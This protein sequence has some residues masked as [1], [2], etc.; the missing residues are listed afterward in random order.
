MPVCPQCNNQIFEGQKFCGYC[1]YKLATVPSLPCPRCGRLN[2]NSKFC[3]YCGVPLTLPFHAPSPPKEP[4]IFS[5]L[6]EMFLPALIFNVIF[7]VL[8]L[9]PIPL[10]LFIMPFL[11]GYLEALMS[12]Q[13]LL[14]MT[15]LG[16]LLGALIIFILIYKFQIGINHLK[17][18]SKMQPGISKAIIFFLVISG[19]I[20]LGTL[21][22]QVIL[23]L[24][25][26]FVQISTE[27][28][29]PYDI[30]IT[31]S[32]PFDILLIIAAVVIVGPIFEELLFRGY[33][34]PVLQNKLKLGSFAAV[35]LSSLFF[36]TLHVQA[37][38]ASSLYFTII[39]F[40]GTF[41]LGVVLGILYV[42]TEDVRVVIF[43]HGLNNSLAVIFTLLPQ[44]EFYFLL[45]LVLSLLF[46]SS[47]VVFILLKR[48]EIIPFFQASWGGLKEILTFKPLVNFFIVVLVSI[49]IPLPLILLGTE[50]LSLTFLEVGWVLIVFSLYIFTLIVSTVFLFVFRPKKHSYSH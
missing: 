15:I 11:G 41:T 37:D 10:S 38:I 1:G 16:D 33:L 23:D 34:L 47:F 22:F 18:K 39:H 17:S 4:S 49:I 14:I 50:Q 20:F 35:F 42:Q 21:I 46:L 19:F 44:N 25:F 24:V 29:S 9:S 7:C 2:S 12:S 6:R 45:D 3:I 5:H 26:N 27:V 31:V 30:L 8:I 28:S 40:F 13:Y 36:A 48:K 43:F 32:S